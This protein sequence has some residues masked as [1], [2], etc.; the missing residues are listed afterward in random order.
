MGMTDKQ[1]DAYQIQLLEN[2]RN[3]RA[4]LKDVEAVKLDKIIANIEESLRRS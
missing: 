3:A 4:D 1:F 2:L